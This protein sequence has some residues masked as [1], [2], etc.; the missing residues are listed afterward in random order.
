MAKKRSSKKVSAG[1]AR[2]KAVAK[3]DNTLSPHGGKLVNRVVEDREK[4]RRLASKAKVELPIRDQHAREIVSMAYGFFSPLDGFMKEAD[5]ASICKKMTLASGYVWSIPIVF[6]LSDDEIRSM[7]IKEGDTILLKYQNQPFATLEVEE[8]YSFD[9]KLMAVSVYGTDDEKHPGV[10]RTYQYKDKF[11]GGR[12]TLINPPV[13]N[14]PFDK[15]WYPPAKS[16][17]KFKEFGWKRAV[18]H[19]TRNVP[20][21]GH[22]WLMK[23]AWFEAQSDVNPNECGVLVNCVVGEK[24]KGDYIDEAIVLSHAALGENGYFKQGTHMVSILLWDMRYAGP[25]EAIFHAIVRKN[26]GCTHHMFGRDHAGVGDYYDK[27]A[28]HEIFKKIPNLGIKSVLTLEWW[29]CPTCAEVTYEGL[30]GHKPQKF[31]GSVLRSILLDGV[32]PTRLVMRPEVFDTVMMAADKYGFGNP[33]VD[34]KY[35][36]ERNPVMTVPPMEV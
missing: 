35:L 5:V 27:Y 33:F 29:Y 14:P 9:K 6:D 20:H 32:K 16:R 15:F 7:G 17:E 30:C 26:M 11:L 8:I 12:I 19:Q 22:E 31:S 1:R 36:N 2:K 34:D 10:K 18:A 21:T 28:A 13:I 24:R 23:G 3:V 4:A 25:K